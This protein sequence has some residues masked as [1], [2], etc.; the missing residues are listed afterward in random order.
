MPL[1]TLFD[2][3]HSI[4]F[5]VSLFSLLISFCTIHFLLLISC[6]LQGS[7]LLFLILKFSIFFL[8][9]NEL[10][11]V[12]LVHPEWVS[13]GL[14]LRS[15]HVDGWKE[16]CRDARIGCGLTVTRNLLEAT[17]GG[18]E[19]EPHPNLGIQEQ[20]P[21]PRWTLPKGFLLPAPS[22]NTLLSTMPCLSHNIILRSCYYVKRSLKYRKI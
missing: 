5:S 22:C 21:C 2:F 8:L 19:Q 20:D 15:L 18:L 16:D 1:F 14:Y 4:Y 10:F 13:D 17:G 7:S 11:T 9:K 6:F 12:G 3:S